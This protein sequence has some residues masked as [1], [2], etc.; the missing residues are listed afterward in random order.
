MSRIEVI[1][2]VVMFGF[3]VG[4]ER[5]EF[6]FSKR[7]LATLRRAAEILDLG[8]TQVREYLGDED[9]EEEYQLAEPESRLFNFLESPVIRL[10]GRDDL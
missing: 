1:P 7:E 6:R 5:A 9:T 2:P 8:R 4:R 3:T 10:P